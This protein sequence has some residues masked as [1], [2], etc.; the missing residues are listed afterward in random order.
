MGYFGALTANLMSHRQKLKTD[1]TL[2]HHSA[3]MEHPGPRAAWDRS[4][5]NRNYDKHTL[6]SSDV[7]NFIVTDNS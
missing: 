6:L 3:G 1:V 4:V 2:H 5:I 7:I